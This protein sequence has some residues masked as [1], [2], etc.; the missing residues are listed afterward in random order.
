MSKAANSAVSGVAGV[1][2][3][4]TGGKKEPKHHRIAEKVQGVRQQRQ[5]EASVEVPE[6]E[7]SE[8][9]DVPKSYF[10]YGSDKKG[11]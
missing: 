8:H 9:D 5:E 6:P 7:A 10:T 4:F 11:E 1:V 3:K 2:G